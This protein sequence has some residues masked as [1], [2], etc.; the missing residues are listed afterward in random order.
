MSSEETVKGKESFEQ[1]A[2]THGVHIKHY[3]VDNGRF[4]DN[5]FMK[6]IER[7]NQTISFSGVGGAHHQNGIAEKRIGDLQRRATAL[8]L[9]AERRWPDA[10]NSIW[11]QMIVETTFQI[12]IAWN[13]Q[14]QNS[15]DQAR[16]Q[17]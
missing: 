7:N 13:A 15:Q 16:I 12:K 6:A 17:S 10:I 11:Q 9:H 1:F 4:K 14:S 2:R 8:L 3:H 5:L